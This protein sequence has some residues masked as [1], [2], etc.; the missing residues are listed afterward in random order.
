L[1]EEAWELYLKA[2]DIDCLSDGSKDGT[3]GGFSL[4][5]PMATAFPAL[6]S[7][8]LPQNSFRG[9]LNVHSRTAC[10]L[11]K[12][13]YRALYTGGFSRFV[14]YPTAPVPVGAKITGRD[15]HP[16]KNSAFSRSTTK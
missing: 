3:I 4:A 15:S 11:A 7:G 9:L 1:T 5:S 12:L 14:T 8:R 16:L 6:S 10:M 13:L 2:L